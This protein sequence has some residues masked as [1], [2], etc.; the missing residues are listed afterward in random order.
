MRIQEILSVAAGCLSFSS[1]KQDVTQDDPVPE[2]NLGYEIHRAVVNVR[3]S[4]FLRLF[5]TAKS[6]GV[7]D[8]QVLRL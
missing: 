1:I 3:N 6:C 8:Q 4:D 2:V 5:P 7:D